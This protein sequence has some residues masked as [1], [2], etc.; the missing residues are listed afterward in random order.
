MKEWSNKEH[1]KMLEEKRQKAREKEL[2]ERLNLDSAA[3]PKTKI[4]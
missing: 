2:T 4:V 1:E 3:V